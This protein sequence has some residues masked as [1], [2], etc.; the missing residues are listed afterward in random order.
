M[1]DQTNTGVEYFCGVVVTRYQA[2][3][4]QFINRVLLTARWLE[5]VTAHEQYTR[6]VSKMIR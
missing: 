2:C 5:T 4:S 6:D 1:E 3:W